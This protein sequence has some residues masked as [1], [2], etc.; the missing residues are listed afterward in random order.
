M[1]ESVSVHPR[2]NRAPGGGGGAPIL[3]ENLRPGSRLHSLRVE[4]PPTPDRLAAQVNP[5]NQPDL[6]RSLSWA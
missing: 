1:S 4:K 5:H 6:S 2:P 3:P